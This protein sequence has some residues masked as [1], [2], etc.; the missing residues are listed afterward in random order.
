VEINPTL[1]NKGNKM[2]EVAF[3]ILKIAVHQIRRTKGIN[4]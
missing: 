4:L 1:D 2:A 3:D